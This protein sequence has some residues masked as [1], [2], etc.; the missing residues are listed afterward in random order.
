MGFYKLM[1]VS[2]AKRLGNAKFR[3]LHKRKTKVFHFVNQTNVLINELWR[4][5]LADFVTFR[6]S[7]ASSSAILA[8][9]LTD[10]WLYYLI[11]IAWY[12]SSL[13]TLCKN[14]NKH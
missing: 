6:Q 13:V 7:Q 4:C 11:H 1:L 9:K 2:L 8:P 14:A 5:W 3:Y 10:C 12:L